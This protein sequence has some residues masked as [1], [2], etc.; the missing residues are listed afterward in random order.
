MNIPLEPQFRC[1]PLHRNQRFIFCNIQDVN[2]SI[3]LVTSHIGVRTREILV[4]D[5]CTSESG[6]N[7][8]AHP[9]AI[10]RK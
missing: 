6:Q 2:A 3:Q 5:V 8:V 1:Y 7:V 4:I 10:G 9:V